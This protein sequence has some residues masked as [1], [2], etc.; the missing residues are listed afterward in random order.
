MTLAG[1]PGHDGLVGGYHSLDDKL[2]GWSCFQGAW[3]TFI[4][5]N[6]KKFMVIG[7]IHAG[8]DKKT[9]PT[10]VLLS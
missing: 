4:L 5:W 6:K 9:L 2:K 3:A 8:L 1:L 10:K 7:T